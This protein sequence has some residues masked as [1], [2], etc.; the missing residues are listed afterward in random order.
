MNMS[1]D[2]E[3]GGEQQYKD[4]LVWHYERERRLK[5]N[6]TIQ[7][8]HTVQ[9][10]DGKNRFFIRSNFLLISNS[11]FIDVL[12]PSDLPIDLV[13]SAFDFV[14]KNA[15]IYAVTSPVEM[16][17]PVLSQE[18]FLDFDGFQDQ[19]I[20]TKDCKFTGRVFFYT[21]YLVSDQ[22]KKM[23]M[24][25]YR[26]HDM[27]LI[28][29]DGAWIS[30]MQKHIDRPVVF[31]GH[32]S[33]DKNNLVRELAHRIDGREV[34]VWYDEISLKPG[35]RL[36]K[37]LDAGLEKANYFMPIITENWMKNERY[38][39]YE[40]DAI[41]QKYITE[42]S[43]IIVP[44]CVGVNPS[45]LPEKSRVL[46]DILAIVHRPEDTVES[47]ANKIINAV[48]PRIPAV[49]EPLPP[50]D[51]QNKHGFFSVGLVVGP[52]ESQ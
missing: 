29:R 6:G 27:Y 49:G 47:L 12:L 4:P 28:V 50:I 42:K 46:A 5:I 23:L 44:V 21:S 19:R 2:A 45:R 43:V 17:V 26:S 1:L 13:S 10:A 20:S 8:E 51:F 3:G 39:E 30:A 33:S 9:D 16:A 35:D 15:E 34:Q 24:D 37:S 31:L 32:D 40:F 36:R 38:A 18:G 52:K 22:D 14:S 48:D 7:W 25:M 11:C 41:M